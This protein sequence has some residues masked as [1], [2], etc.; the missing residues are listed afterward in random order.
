MTDNLRELFK[1]PFQH[2]GESGTMILDSGGNLIAE[3]RGWGR[4][5]T[6]FDEEEATKLQNEIGQLIADALNEKWSEAED[7]AFTDFKMQPR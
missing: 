4:L 3:V 1:P 2:V 6:H 7:K 5:S